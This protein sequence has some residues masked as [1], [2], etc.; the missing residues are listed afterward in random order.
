MKTHVIER[1]ATSRAEPE[2]VFALLADAPGWPSWSPLGATVMV[3]ESPDGPGGVGEVHRFDTGRYR[4][5]E[6][7]VVSDRPHHF[8]YVLV[9]GL[10]LKNYRADVT[11]EAVDGGSRI[12]W[13]STFQAKVPLTGWIFRRRLGSFIGEIVEA[14]AARASA[15]VVG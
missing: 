10:P 12:T 8:A 7:V 9:S 1:Q 14:L 6:E 2:A 13:R 4:S 15:S 11:V 5:L 3:Q